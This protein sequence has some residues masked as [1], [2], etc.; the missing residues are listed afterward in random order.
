VNTD[1]RD[2]LLL[3]LSTLPLSFSVAKVGVEAGVPVA[4]II[5][6]SFFI[7][8]AAAQII[9]FKSFDNSL[10]VLLAVASIIGIAARIGFYAQDIHHSIS[11]QP[12][13]K[14]ILYLLPL[15]D[16]SYVEYRRLATKDPEAA[17]SRYSVISRSLW[18]S[19]QVGVIAGVAVDFGRSDFPTEGVSVLIF[20]CLLWSVF[21]KPS[22]KA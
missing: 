3:A 18:V 22:L 7:F 5:G 9:L 17:V 16:I 21:A 14:R 4:I 1:T 20:L 11:E 15:T 10:S 13:W 12:L 19:W 8:S 6:S 2:G